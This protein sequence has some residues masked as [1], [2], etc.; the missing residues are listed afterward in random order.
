MSSTEVG[1]FSLQPAG[2]PKLLLGT[3]N[4]AAIAFWIVVKAKVDARKNA[5][6]IH[7]KLDFFTWI[8]FSIRETKKPRRTNT[9]SGLGYKVEMFCFYR[10]ITNKTIELRYFHPTDNSMPVG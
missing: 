2:L 8:P 6:N 1:A 3:S 9:S 10:K 5:H 7:K 4:P